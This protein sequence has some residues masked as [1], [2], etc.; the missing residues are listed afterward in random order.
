MYLMKKHS[1]EHGDSA[2]QLCPLQGGQQLGLV[3][4]LPLH[5]LQQQ[6][7]FFKLEILFF[8]SG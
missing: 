1:I 3:I 2:G 6:Q 5:T 8:L 7:L 4:R